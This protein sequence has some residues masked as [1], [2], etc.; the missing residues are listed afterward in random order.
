MDTR[1]RL[2]NPCPCGYLD[3]PRHQRTCSPAQIHRYLRRVSGLLLD[4]IDIHIEVPSVPFGKEC[5][6]RD[7]A[8]G[9]LGT[10]MQRLGLSARAYALRMMIVQMI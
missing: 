9:L 8:Q 4:R 1:K 2:L 6:L 3:D 10:A 5:K 7:N